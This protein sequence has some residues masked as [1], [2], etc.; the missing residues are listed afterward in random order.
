LFRLAHLC[1]ADDLDPDETFAVVKAG[2]LAWGKFHKRRNGDR[3][4]QEIV[5]RAWS[6]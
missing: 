4:L 5:T 1:R 2:D 3:Y 6:E